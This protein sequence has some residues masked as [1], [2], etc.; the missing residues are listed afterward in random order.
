MV[1]VY[2]K[3][4][5]HM[6]IAVC[7]NSKCKRAYW[8]YRKDHPPKRFCSVVCSQARRQVEE[9]EAPA[10]ILQKVYAHRLLAHGSSDILMYWGCEICDELDTEY[11]DSLAIHNARISRDI[12][13]DAKTARKIEREAREQ[14]LEIERE[15]WKVK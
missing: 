8:R 1:L 7:S 12:A 15:Y 4:D 5:A 11:R 9:V 2:R 10:K 3:A 13:Q 14:K 6:S